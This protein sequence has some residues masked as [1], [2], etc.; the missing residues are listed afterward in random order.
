MISRSHVLLE[1]FRRYGQAPLIG[2]LVTGVLA[3]LIALL[4]PKWYR[5]ESTLLPP[6]EN[7]ESFSVLASLVEASALSKVGLLST[8]ST[9]DLYVEMLTSRRVRE[10]VLGRFKLQDRYHI[11]NLDLC[12]KELDE[13]LKVE[14]L[15]SKVIQIRVEDRDPVVAAAMANAFVSELDRLNQELR[16]R[17]ASDSRE[18]LTAQLTTVE[19][20]LHGA[21]TRLTDYERNSGVFAGSEGAAVQGAADLLSRKLALEVRKSWIESYSDPGSPALQAT[22][23]ELEAVDRESSRLPGL[24]QE[25]SRRALDVEIQRRVFTLLTAQLEQAQLEEH[26]RVTTLSV[27][28][29][30]RAPTAKTRPRRGLIIGIST[31]IAL[32]VAASW[33]LYRT[34]EELIPQLPDA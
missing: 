27:L 32:L 15:R 31:G 21:E 28:D 10:A 14:A 18:Y 22:R 13:H 17:R 11:Q 26:R 4:L 3:T 6:Q 29:S 30:A 33:V 12:L 16:A 34:R 1:G 7:G 9:S 8:T 25:V 5:A 20:R 24:K 23:S 2:V 19:Q